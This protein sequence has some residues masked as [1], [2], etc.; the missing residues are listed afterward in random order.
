MVHCSTLHGHQHTLCG[1]V[2]EPAG[3]EAC[4]PMGWLPGASSLRGAAMV[5][6]VALCAPWPGASCAAADGADTSKCS[7]A[8]MTITPAA[9]VAL[10]PLPPLLMLLAPQQARIWVLPGSGVPP[11]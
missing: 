6:V 4:S 10:P 11:A 9:A 3:A 1:L 7:S 5:P 2:P 8:S